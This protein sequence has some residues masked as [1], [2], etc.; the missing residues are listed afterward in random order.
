MS[1]NK[2]NSE[3]KKK[4]NYELIG[5]DQSINAIKN[6]Y[7][8]VGINYIEYYINVEISELHDYFENAFV[9]PE[10]VELSNLIDSYITICKNKFE[11]VS[12]D[13]L[14]YPSNIKVCVTKDNLY[15][16][17]IFTLEDII[18]IKYELLINVFKSTEGPESKSKC[19]QGTIINGNL[20]DN[21]LLSD[22]FESILFI[23]IRNNLDNWLKYF[24]LKFNCDILYKSN[25]DFRFESLPEHY[26]SPNTDYLYD[27]FILTYSE[28]KTYTLM[29]IIENTEYKYQPYIGTNAYEIS[30]RKDQM[31]FTKINKQINFSSNPFDDFV[32]KMT[33]IIFG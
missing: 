4:L 26:L 27:F 3:Y 11:S 16:D 1:I 15:S 6:F 32:K 10:N 24:T 31:V 25:I 13:L 12:N 9:E 2:Y 22:I 14:I 23:S 20:Y 29:D 7:Q 17:N 18:F 5:K 33:A 8:K 30:I 28:N 19:Y 21:E